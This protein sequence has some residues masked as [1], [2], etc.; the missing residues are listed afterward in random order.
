MIVINRTDWK[1][2][3]EPLGTSWSKNGAEVAVGDYKPRKKKPEQSHR[4]MTLQAQ[5]QEEN[6][7]DT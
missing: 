2:I 3:S 4:K 1:L 5:P 7:G 6:N